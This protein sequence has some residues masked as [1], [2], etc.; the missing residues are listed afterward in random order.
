MSP[1]NARRH[2]HKILPTWIPK[3]EHLNKDDIN[4]HA[5]MDKSGAQ[6]ASTLVKELQAAKE[7][8]EWEK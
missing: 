1:R 3:P 4:R 7:C 5:N 2:T 6:G 8:R